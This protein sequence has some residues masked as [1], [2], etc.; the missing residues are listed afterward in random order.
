MMGVFMFIGGA[1]GSTAGGIK[2]N[3]VAVMFAYLRSSF[4]NRPSVTL[5]RNSLAQNTVLR[6]FLIFL[7]GVSAVAVGAV[8]LL[9][10]ERA[11]AEHVMFEVISAFGTVGLSAGITGTLTAGGK[12]VISVLMFIGRLGPL[13][14]LAAAS[15]SS[16][17][18][19]IEYPRGEI[20]IG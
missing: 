12:V 17:R 4:M 10:L 9:V 8:V 7:F 1:S 19:K 3:T 18:A 11:P 20:A 2:I 16:Q 14:L 13:T 6:S 5:H 15:L